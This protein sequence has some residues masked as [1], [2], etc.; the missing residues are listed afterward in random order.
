[1][2]N[3][4]LVK[5]LRLPPKWLDRVADNKLPESLARLIVPLLE[6]PPV[7]SELDKI[8]KRHDG[9]ESRN[10]LQGQIENLTR[11]LTR[12]FTGDHYSYVDHDT[13]RCLID[14]KDPKVREQ[15]AIVKIGDVE[16]ATNV[17][18]FKELQDAA[19]TELVKKRKAAETARANK[20]GAKVSPAA[21]K[22]KAEDKRKLLEIRI[23]NWR[24]HWLA[25]IIAA[26]LDSDP[27]EVLRLLMWF[28][29]RSRQWP[30]NNGVPW[31]TLVDEAAELA[32]GKP[33]KR[34]SYDSAMDAWDLLSTAGLPG[35]NV[36]LTT[37]ATA[38]CSKVLNTPDKDKWHPNIPY[39][40]IEEIAGSIDL[41][42][43]WKDLYTKK[44][45]ALETFYAIFTT[46]QLL[47][48]AKELGS[49]AARETNRKKIIAALCAKPVNLPKCL[50]LKNTKK[51]S[52]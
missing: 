15:L 40:V 17:V 23:R 9:F 21:Q 10:S 49:L 51:G 13:H 52:K 50:T 36:S 43:A 39:A 1:M 31:V 18:K 26:R 41:T 30:A 24:H 42:Y 3:S 33:I 35:S 25:S 29:V 22:Q 44:S 19:V 5:L 2:R 34:T 46:E 12:K 28:L 37:A 38:F 14:T 4:N 6:V 7:M 16:V 32:G 47:E 11:N 45:L 27:T 48:L 8:F 20:T